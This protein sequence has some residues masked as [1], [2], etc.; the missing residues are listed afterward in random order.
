MMD[1]FDPNTINAAADKAI[2]MLM[3][4][5][6]NLIGAVLI[7]MIGL[8]LAKWLSSTVSKLFSSRR[9]IDPT[10]VP[11]LASLV[12]YGIIIITLIAVLGQLGMQIASILAV[13]G[14]AGLAIGLALQGTL[15]NIAAGLMLLWLRPFRVGDFIKTGDIAGS[16]QEIGLFASHLKTYDGIFHFVPN[17]ELW[18]KP[19]INLTHMPTRMLDLDVGIDYEDDIDTAVRTLLGIAENDERVLKDPAPVSMV[20]SL[21]DSSVNLKLRC[22]VKTP[23]YWAVFWEY[24]QRMKKEL[25]AQGLSIPFPQRTVHHIQDGGSQPM[26]AV[27]AMSVD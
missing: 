9:Q 11:V 23:D 12:R 1:W 20:A 13:L 5:V 19:I 7:L 27:P 17:S 3:E 8:V 6:P 18:N 14:A 25:E 24:Q 4:F 2:A 10:L 21:G 22:W 15:S 16:V 26:M